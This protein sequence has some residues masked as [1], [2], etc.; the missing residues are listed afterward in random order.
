ME[1]ALHLLMASLV[2]D[3]RR[4]LLEEAPEVDGEKAAAE[5]AAAARARMANFIFG[6]LLQVKT[7]CDM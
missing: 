2:V 1:S 4:A 6:W 7:K 5:P 3:I